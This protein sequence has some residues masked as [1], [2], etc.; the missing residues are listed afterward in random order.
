MVCNKS[1]PNLF[2]ESVFE[3]ALERFFSPW[4]K[5]VEPS[6]SLSSPSFAGAGF[7]SPDLI[8]ICRKN[9]SCHS[10]QV[11]ESEIALCAEVGILIPP[12]KCI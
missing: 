12:C 9:E 3:G 4:K 7:C 8:S 10:I 1:P 11:L 6:F 5:S 2:L